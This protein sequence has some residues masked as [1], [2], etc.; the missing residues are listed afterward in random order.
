MVMVIRI[1]CRTRRFALV[2]DM[3]LW[4]AAM[5]VSTRDCVGCLDAMIWARTRVLRAIRSVCATVRSL[6]RLC[7]RNSCSAIL[8][9]GCQNYGR[10]GYHAVPSILLARSL[11]IHICRPEVLCGNAS[12]LRPGLFGSQDLLFISPR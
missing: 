7:K 8:A 5:I 4:P 6:F 11:T 12:I 9:T 2:M 1:L 3:L 10:R